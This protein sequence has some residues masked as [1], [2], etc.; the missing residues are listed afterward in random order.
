MR[1]TE[2]DLE[3]SV[4]R[5]NIAMGASELAYS[6]GEDG[7]L[8]SN[9]GTY[10]LS[11][12]YGGWKLIRYENEGGGCSDVSSGGYVSKKDLYHQIQAMINFRLGV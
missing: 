5:L 8:R 3:G 2:R 6:R 10:D 12:A 9:V 11:G 1:I 4:K 7:K